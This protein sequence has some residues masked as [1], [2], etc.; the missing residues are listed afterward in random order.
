MTVEHTE[1][2]RLS[3]SDL[4]VIGT[5]LV[6]SFVVIL[7][8][9]VM[10]VAI[11]V[12]Q[13]SLGVLPSVGQWLTTA[14]MLTMAVVIPLTGYLIQRFG[15]RAMFVAAMTLFTLG[16]VIAAVAP[17]FGVLL[18]ARV[19]QALGT[20]IMLPLLMTTVMTL[21]P[22]ERRGVMMG[23]ISVVISVAPALGPTL[24]GFILDH[25]SWRAIFYVVAPIAAATLVIGASAIRD[26]GERSTAPM[27]VV[28]IP[29]AIFGFGGL[30]YGLAGIGEAVEGDSAVPPWIPLVVGAIALAAFVGRQIVLQRTD[31]ALLDLRVFKS[32]AF[33][34]SVIVML[35]GMATMMGTFIVVPYFAQKVLELDAFR[36]GLIT[37]PGGIVMGVASPLI[38]RIYDVRGPRPLVIPGTVLI[39]SGA[40]IL[41]TVSV[42]SSIWLLLAAN[43]VLCLGLAATFTPLMT[44]GLSSV[45]PQL[46]SYGSAVVG[47]LQQVAG[48]VGT[49][50]F[51]TVMTVV[52]TDRATSG[53]AV[54]QAI[55]D[56]VRTVFMVAGG[57][58]V[59]LIILGLLVRRPATT[60]DPQSPDRLDDPDDDKLAVG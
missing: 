43:L 5:L 25:F 39:A 4:T 12:L 21:V 58:G 28:S 19:I 7:N 42:D 1:P 15:T 44:L 50:L 41:T 38:G 6:A 34:L 59:V 46:Y 18:A 31:R 27:D 36:T 40:W 32:R 10:S 56:G 47:T 45:P 35:A 54:P 55:T 3:R 37:L 22:E 51:I 57:L 26:V 60:V 23:N 53:V 2:H 9:T 30:V 20:A 33:T 11:P 49:A 48:A 24:S 29:L 16:T 8:E 13:D 52:A 14:F 17:G